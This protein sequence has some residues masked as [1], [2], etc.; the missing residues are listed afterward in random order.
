[1]E[2]Q[3][4]K[5][6][7]SDKIDESINLINKLKQKSSEKFI[8][9]HNQVNFQIKKIANYEQIMNF[10]YSCKI[11]F[12]KNV[13][14]FNK[15]YSTNNFITSYFLDIL[16]GLEKDFNSIKK[17]NDSIRLHNFKKEKDNSLARLKVEYQELERKIFKVYKWRATDILDEIIE[18]LNFLILVM[19]NINKLKEK[20]SEGIQKFNGS[21]GVFKKGNFEEG[22]YIINESI[23]DFL[24]VRNEIEELFVNIIKIGEKRKE[25]P[26]KKLYNLQENLKQKYNEII[27]LNKQNVNR[28]G[29]NFKNLE[30]IMKYCNIFLEKIKKVH[31]IIVNEYITTKMKENS[32]RLDILIILDTTSSMEDYL[33][34]FK[35]EFYQ[36]VEKIKELCPDILIY[37]GLIGYKDLCDKE[38]GD[39]YINI[40]FTL[41]YDKLINLI[42]EIEP[43]GGGDIPE[44]VAGAFD[45]ALEKSWQGKTK[46]AFLITDSPNHGNEYED[47]EE[48]KDEKIEDNIIVNN[49]R[50]FDDIIKEFCDKNISLFCLD[51]HENT[52]KM[53]DKFK[54]TY[55]EVNSG[56]ERNNI[57]NSTKNYF[58]IEKEDFMNRSII[59]K[60]INLYKRE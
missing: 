38:V 12:E 36:M 8:L 20:I 24:I 29:I 32:L 21:M 3:G 52:K 34:K 28:N 42:N 41:D 1:M 60:I 7:I 31:E 53:F 13:N 59:N 10:I 57:N 45:L 50:A 23:R 56:R 2:L 22:K 5:E 4:I 58:Y 15:L 39:D 46:I 44:D 47:L 17:L 40:D 33:K 9:S 55:E 48:N 25:N 54:Q 49:E 27:I 35:I 14:N 43:D 6:S 30:N 51:L 19:D 11:I 16:N 26:L 37:F 18:Y